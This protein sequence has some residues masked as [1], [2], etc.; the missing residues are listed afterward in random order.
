[1]RGLPLCDLLVPCGVI[2]PDGLFVELGKNHFDIGNDAKVGAL[3]FI[4]F[5]EIDV[6]MDDEGVLREGLDRTR[7][8]VVETR[9][10]GEQEIAFVDGVVG[11]E[12]PVHSGPAEGQGI[13]VGESAE[14]HQRGRDGHIVIMGELAEFL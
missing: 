11:I 8:A 1:M 9:S 10:E 6:H 14:T 7:D 2:L 13:V 4:D 5:R 3:V 12:G